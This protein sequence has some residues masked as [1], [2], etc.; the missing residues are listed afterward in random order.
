LL[1]KTPPPS[2]RRGSASPDIAPITYMPGATRS[3]FITPS[4]FGPAALKGAVP[5]ISAKSAL[6]SSRPIKNG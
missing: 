5:S 2:L 4:A 6:P 1:A 3:G